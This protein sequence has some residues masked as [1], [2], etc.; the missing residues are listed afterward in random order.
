MDTDGFIVHIKTGDVCENI[1]N[2][3]EKAFYIRLSKIN[4]ILLK[5]HH[6]QVKIKKWLG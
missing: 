6:P 4:A 1:A 5:D 3:V 2:D